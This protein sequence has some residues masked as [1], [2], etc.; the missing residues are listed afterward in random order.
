MTRRILAFI[1]SATAVACGGTIANDHVGSANTTGASVLPA[2]I[3]LAAGTSIEFASANLRIRFD[4]VTADSR[5]PSNV[6]C[7]QAGSATVALTATKLSGIESAQLLSLSTMAGKDTATSYGQ[8]VRLLTVLPMPITTTPTQ[9][10][11]YR[12]ELKIG[13]EK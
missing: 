7:I 5:C 2:T 13:S 9:P 4:S 3:T 1:L 10:L 6:Q 12:I 11:Q 8:A